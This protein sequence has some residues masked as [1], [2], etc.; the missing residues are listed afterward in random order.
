[1]TSTS[2][3]LG[4]VLQSRRTGRLLV[5]LGDQL[6]RRSRAVADLDR[7]RDVVFMAEVRNE[8]EHVP[9]HPQR[10]ALFLSAMRHYARELSDRNYRV[11]YIRLDDNHNTGTLSGELK[12]AVTTLRPHSVRCIEPGEHRVR[13]DLEKA[14]SETGAPL[15]VSTD[16]TFTC[17]LDFFNRWSAGRSVLVMEHFYRSRRRELGLLMDGE[18][19]VAGRWNF[20]ADN[21]KSFRQ[22][23]SVPEPYRARPDAVTHEVTALV[24]NTYPRAAGRIGSLRWPVSPGQA[25]RS[26]KNF[27]DRRLARFGDFQDAMWTGEPVL[28][29]STLSPALNL[30]LLTP[31]ECVDA[32]IGAW[33]NGDAAINNVEAFVRQVIGWREFARGVYYRE[34]P[35]YSGRNELGHNGALP[36]FYWT[37]DTEMNCLRHCITEVLENGHGHHI[38]RLMVV[39]NFALIA[40]VEPQAVNAWFLGMYVDGVEWATAPNVIGMSQYADGGVVATKPYAASGKYINRM[41]NYCRGCRYDVNQ[42]TGGD[43]CPFNTFY[44]DFL[45]RHRR[46]FDKNPRM[47]LAMGHLRRITPRDIRAIRAAADRLRNQIEL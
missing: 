32:A 11:H 46:R 21:R 3:V 43:A 45:I 42:R 47:S 16:E 35:N 30:K 36:P 26:L 2:G 6:Y 19:P 12:R 28:Y 24:A 39:G 37:G 4:P 10:T 17:S 20:D 14:C 15:D 29:H 7:R 44:W 23:P 38:A 1:M 31:R 40:G 13:K 9:S 18:K 25:R 5:V 41:S 33:E 8:A 22:S 34:G 27:V